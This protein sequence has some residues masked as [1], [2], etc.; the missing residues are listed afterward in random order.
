MIDDL[1]YKNAVIYSLDLETFMDLNG[2]GV[3]GPRGLWVVAGGIEYRAAT[4]GVAQCATAD[5]AA[6]G[7]RSTRSVRQA[8]PRRLAAGRGFL[9]EHALS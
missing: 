5:C 3:L 7:G 6:T 8:P 2:D 1:W 4:D 9:T